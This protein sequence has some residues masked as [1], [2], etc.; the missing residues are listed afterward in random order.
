MKVQ[1]KIQTITSSSM[2]G[3]SVSMEKAGVDKVAFFSFSI[4]NVSYFHNGWKDVLD[5]AHL[6]FSSKHG[7]CIFLDAC[8]QSLASPRLLDD[9]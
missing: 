3:P 7:S 1:V 6:L 8:C 2:S 5:T 4:F 9:W